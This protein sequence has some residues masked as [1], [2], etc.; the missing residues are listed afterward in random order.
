ME[1]IY[2]KR[3]VFTTLMAVSFLFGLVFFITNHFDFCIKAL[4]TNNL[5]I[6]NVA[7]ILIHII[8]T[9]LMPIVFLAHIRI[10]FGRIR[11]AKA[12]FIILGILHIATLGW[13]ISFLTSNPSIDLLSNAKTAAFQSDASKA[14]VYNYVTWDTYNWAGSIFALIYGAL[15]IITGIILDDNR[16]KVRIAV[17]VM[18]LSRIIF[19]LIHNIFFQRRILSMFWITNNYAVLIS[20]AAFTAAIIIASMSD[21][22]WVECVWDAVPDDPDA[23]DDDT[24]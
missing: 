7:Y 5:N 24:M 14:F 18:F 1:N 12:L 2:D 6:S 17:I 19:P 11:I 3:S 4:E 9:I 22:S 16:V 21:F 15:C 20:L 13:T 23:E 8:T 10:E